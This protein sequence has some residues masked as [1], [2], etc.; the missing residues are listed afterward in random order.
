MPHRDFRQRFGW[1]CP[2]E[3]KLAAYVEGRL[4]GRD[5]QRLQSHLVD[6]DACRDTVGFLVRAA[7]QPL[8]PAA[9]GDYIAAASD[10]RPQA[11]PRARTLPWISAGLLTAVVAVVGVFLLLRVTP[12][13]LRP[14]IAAS[15]A[16]IVAKIEPPAPA[17]PADRHPVLRGSTAPAPLA[18]IS[19]AANSTLPASG[20]L[21]FAWGNVRHASY[22]E[23]RVTDASGGPVWQ[24]RVESNEARTSADAFKSGTKYFVWVRAFLD[25][26]SS[27]E[28]PA[29][30]FFVS[31]GAE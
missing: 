16:P 11:P 9:P 17:A 7:R 10:V 14:S 1:T 3:E 30:P 22:Y 2:D 24:S 28:S 15:K 23:I 26:G 18:L 13:E 8:A 12:D 19:P 25:D 27:V 4:L 20:R 21:R 29:V 5:K 31:R 6:C